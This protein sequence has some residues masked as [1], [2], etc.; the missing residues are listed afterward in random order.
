[1]VL[2]ILAPQFL[3]FVLISFGTS[4]NS[5]HA[6]GLLYTSSAAGTPPLHKK[7]KVTDS[8]LFVA[9]SDLIKFMFK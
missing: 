1:M 5:F 3:Q 4:V 2:I 6:N 8:S 9:E 7:N